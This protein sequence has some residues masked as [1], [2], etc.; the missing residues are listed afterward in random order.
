MQEPGSIREARVVRK[1]ID[2]FTTTFFER[3]ETMQLTFDGLRLETLQALASDPGTPAEL[4]TKLSN[5]IQQKGKGATGDGLAL[6]HDPNS[7]I[8]FCAETAEQM[9]NA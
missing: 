1:L 5:L 9:A 3:T 2:A 6:S 7:F 4:K 8:N